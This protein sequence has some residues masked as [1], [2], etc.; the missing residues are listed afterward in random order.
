MAFSHAVVVRYHTDTRRPHS[1][2]CNCF[3]A[4]QTDANVHI[5]GF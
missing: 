5:K 2:F 1:G 4:Q 3:I